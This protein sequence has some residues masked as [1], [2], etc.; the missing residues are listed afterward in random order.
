MTMQAFTAILRPLTAFATPLAGD[1]LFGQLCWT[2]RYGWGEARLI[3]LLDAYTAGQPF[4]VIGDALPAGYLPLPALPSLHWQGG[5]DDPMERKALKSIAWA[6]ADLLGSPLASWQQQAKDRRPVGADFASRPQPRNS[7]NRLTG[8]T[9][10]GDGFA[11]YTVRQHW[12]GKEAL[13]E[14]H[15]R[16]DA[17]RLSTDELAQALTQLGLA[18]FGKDANV[19]LGKFELVAIRAAALAGQTDPDAWLTLGPCAPQGLSWEAARCFYRPL[20]RYGRHGD[21]AARGRSPFKSP[22]LLVAAGALLAPKIETDWARGW[23]GQGLGG[24]GSISTDLPQ[25]VHQGYA[26]AIPVR[27]PESLAREAA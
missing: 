9:G 4:L 19:G 26:P 23:I 25:T 6:P 22:L 24:D 13:L 1:T 5:S 27:L 17:E 12:H 11:P 18:G 16:L 8:A 14:V 15:L 10:K 21:L 7:L 2:I 20:T 3:E